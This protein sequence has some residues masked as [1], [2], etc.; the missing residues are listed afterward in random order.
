MRVLLTGAHGFIGSHVAAALRDAG[1]EVVSCVR[2]PRNESE[3]TCDL[4][5]DIDVSAWLPRT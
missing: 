4:A 2:S 3:I 1:H 5:R